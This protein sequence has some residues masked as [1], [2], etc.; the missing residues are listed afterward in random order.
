MRRRFLSLSVCYF[1]EYSLKLNQIGRGRKHIVQSPCCGILL[2]QYI[3][4]LVLFF[5]CVQIITKTFPCNI[6][7]FFSCRKN[8]IYIGKSSMS[9]HNLCFLSKIRKLDMPL[10][11]PVFLSKIRKLDMPL[12]TPVLLYRSIK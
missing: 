6:Q 7:T 5:S 11:T 9:T 2:L 12:Y 10:Y 4:I 3:Y 1:Q 8:E